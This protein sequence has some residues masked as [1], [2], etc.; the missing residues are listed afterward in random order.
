MLEHGGIVEKI[1]LIFAA[2]FIESNHFLAALAENLVFFCKA[3]FLRTKDVHTYS[4]KSFLAY[5]AVIVGEA[6]DYQIY[7]LMLSC[8]SCGPA[9]LCS[10]HTG[11]YLIVFSHY[12]EGVKN[13][14]CHLTVS[15]SEEF[16]QI[17]NKL[18]QLSR[19]QMQHNHAKICRYIL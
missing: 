9:L 14:G 13:G 6:F 3:E 10:E 7:K 4:P 17:E 8:R 11:V 1:Q 18:V 19:R 15:S 2:V 12:A 5:N 16:F